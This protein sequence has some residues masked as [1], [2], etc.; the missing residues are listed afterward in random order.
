MKRIA[1][2]LLFVLSAGCAPTEP[3][4][5]K[6]YSADFTQYFIADRHFTSAPDCKQGFTLNGKLTLDIYGQAGDSISAE[7]RVD[8]AG[9]TDNPSSSCRA[10]P[11]VF[12]VQGFI[13]G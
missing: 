11:S 12:T 10:L 9:F 3:N 7:G 13:W 5:G 8:I 2:S 4:W 1:A 6:L